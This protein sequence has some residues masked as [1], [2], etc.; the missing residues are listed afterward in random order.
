[1]NVSMIPCVSVALMKA[2]KPPTPALSEVVANNI[3]GEI[4]RARISTDALAEALDIKPDAVRRRLRGAMPWS[5]DEADIVASLC[6]IP[7]SR[8]LET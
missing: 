2:R 7:V 3:R 1:M 5:F 8:L 4:A 6:D